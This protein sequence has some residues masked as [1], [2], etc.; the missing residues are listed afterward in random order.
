MGI[1][2][3]VVGAMARDLV[4]VHGYGASIERGTRDVDFGINVSSWDDFNAL[5]N[6]L[7]ET[8]YQPDPKRIYKLIHEDEAG[9]PW[10]IDILPFGDI[11]DA[12]TSIAWPPK[13][14]FVMNVLGFMEAAEHALQIQ[15]SGDPKMIIPVASPAGI[16]ILK[17]VAWLDR[18]KEYKAKDATDFGYLIQ[19]YT[20]I[21]EIFEAVYE[22][23]CMEAQEWDE[24]KASAMKLGQDAGAI[25]LPATL[26]FLTKELFEQSERKEQFARDM[27]GQGNKSLTECTEWFDIF[28]EA[29][30][31]AAKRT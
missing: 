31:L 18:E 6:R 27:Q 8:G 30:C 24:I 16:C 14:E 15:I 7:L 26:S 13:Q 21:P 25:A 1:R 28:V 9:L 19:S 22:D 10:E 23:G 2:Y 20:K 3:L 4:L 17:L 11:A 5:R 29:F 12:D